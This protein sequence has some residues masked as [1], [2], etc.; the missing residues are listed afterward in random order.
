MKTRRS[1]RNQEIL[2][3]A[4]FAPAPVSKPETNP[5]ASLERQLANCFG[6][7]TRKMIEREIVSLKQRIAFRKALSHSDA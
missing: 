4:L 3:R 5:L 6:A 1:P 7:R 2:F